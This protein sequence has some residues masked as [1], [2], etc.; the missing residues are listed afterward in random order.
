MLEY[1]NSGKMS[2]DEEVSESNVEEVAGEKAIRFS[3]NYPEKQKTEHQCLIP[4]HD[5][6]LLVVTYAVKD[7]FENIYMDVYERLLQSIN[8]PDGK[9]IYEEYDAIKQ[10]DSEEWRVKNNLYFWAHLY[11]G[12]QDP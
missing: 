2:D 11:K 9:T 6:W 12:S 10:K 7:D 1:Y 8:I 3:V 5:E 4:V